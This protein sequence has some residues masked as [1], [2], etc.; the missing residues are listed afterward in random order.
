MKNGGEGGIRIHQF[1]GNKG[2]LRRTLAFYVNG[3]KGAE[4]L[5]PPYCPRKSRIEQQRES[6]VWG[7]LPIIDL[8]VPNRIGTLRRECLDRTLFWTT[9]DLEAKLLDFQHYYNE[10]R[11]HAGRKGH[12]PVRGVNTDRS[13][14]NLSC[15]RWQ[16]H[17]GGLYQNV[18]CRVILVIRHRHVRH[19]TGSLLLSRH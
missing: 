3:K 4:Q 16:K 8:L 17:C 10:H 11:T 5:V 2:V 12:P 19:Y 6:T 7:E 13:L 14:A 9:A 1:D 18:D 15:Y